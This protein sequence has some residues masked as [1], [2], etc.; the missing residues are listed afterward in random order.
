MRPRILLCA[1]V[2][3][4]ALAT[5]ACGTDKNTSS[6]STGPTTTAAGKSD[7][8]TL[9]GTGST[10]VA[11]ILQEWIEQYK[12]AAPGVTI[13]YQGVGSGAGIQQLT[14]KTVDFAGSD[15]T[16][17]PEEQAAL[18]G[19]GAVLQVPWIAGGVAVEYNLPAAKDLKLTAEALAG[20]FAAKITKWDDPAIKGANQGASLPG[21]GIQVV[22]SSDGSGTTAVFTEYLKA[23]AP[24]TWTFG[25]GKEGPWP[26]GTRAKGSDGVTA[27]VKQSEGAIGYA[28]VSYSKQSGLSTASVQNKAGPYTL[29]TADAVTAALAATGPD[30]TLKL[31]YQPGSPA[32]YPITT[33][34]YAIFPK[35]GPD[36]WK[37]GALKHLVEW[38][39]K[40]GR[41]QCQGSGPPET[42]GGGGDQRDAARDPEVH[43]RRQ[44]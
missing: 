21:T 11:P 17:K 3:T 9:S 15:V 26:V 39:L 19:S 28:E 7:S 44:P 10:F 22:H 36:P 12:A 40:S 24:K 38:A 6:T 13:N 8:A 14:S 5:G 41:G 43:G 30:G 2:L 29:P 27:A 20:M 23:A 4:F 42:P 16:L 18:G 35:V 34:T 25:S 31:N 37:S 1:S 32:A 33:T